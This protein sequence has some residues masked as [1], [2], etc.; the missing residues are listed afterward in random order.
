MLANKDSQK[1]HGVLKVNQG[2]LKLEKGLTN[3]QFTIYYLN[4]R[5]SRV[6]G[7]WLNSK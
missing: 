5:T 3:R 4:A 7:K 2:E 1:V 6:N